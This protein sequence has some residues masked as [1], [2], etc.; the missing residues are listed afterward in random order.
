MSINLLSIIYSFHH[1]HIHHNHFIHPSYFN[2]SSNP[3]FNNVIIGMLEEW[4]IDEEK[5]GVLVRDGGSN[6]VLGARL[7]KNSF[8]EICRISVILFSSLFRYNDFAI[9]TI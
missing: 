7:G 8:D 9:F 2:Y 4:N 5:Q 1:I 6:M 3:Q